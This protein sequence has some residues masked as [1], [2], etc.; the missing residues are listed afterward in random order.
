MCVSNMKTVTLSAAEVAI[1]RDMGWFVVTN[2][3]EY[4]PLEM[5]VGETVAILEPWA[6]LKAPPGAYNTDLPPRYIYE[7]DKTEE[8]YRFQYQ[9]PETMPVEAVRR[10][11]TV[12]WVEGGM[13][14]LDLIESQPECKSTII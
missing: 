5:D 13:M 7:A 12:A 14:R 9:P 8:P 2:Q 4:S 3:S 10:R 1:L 6:Q 11:A